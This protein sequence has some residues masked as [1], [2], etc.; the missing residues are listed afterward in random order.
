[1]MPENI[2]FLNCSFK[3]S[4]GARW[5]L[6]HQFRSCTRWPRILSI[7]SYFCGTGLV[8][9]LLLPGGVNRVPRSLCALLQF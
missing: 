8:Y 7:K 3:M 1:M 5:R 6:N 4:Y 2:C 9:Q